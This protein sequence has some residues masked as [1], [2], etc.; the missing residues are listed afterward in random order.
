MEIPLLCVASNQM[1]LS[2]VIITLETL[3]NV[4]DL[5]PSSSL[6]IPYL[7]KW[8]SEGSGQIIDSILDTIGS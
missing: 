8:G 5:E 6:N 3:Q 2:S 7:A 1:D 4:K